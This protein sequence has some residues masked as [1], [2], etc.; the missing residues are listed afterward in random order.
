MQCSAIESS[1]IHPKAV[2]VTSLR[3]IIRKLTETTFMAG[4]SELSKKATV[5]SFVQSI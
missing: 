3:R 1:Q 4:V 5:G 2:C